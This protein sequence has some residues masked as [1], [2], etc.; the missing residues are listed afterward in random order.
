[1]KILRG[2]IFGIIFTLIASTAVGQGTRKGESKIFPSDKEIQGVCTVESIQFNLSTPC[3]ASEPAEGQVCWSDDDKTLAVG[4]PGGEVVG[5]MFQEMYIPGRVKNETGG[6][7]LNGTVVF[8]NGTSGGKFTV[9]KADAS[10]EELSETTIGVVTED[11]AHN[12]LGHVT[13]FGLVRGSVAQPIDT[14]GMTPGDDLYLSE[15]AGEWTDSKPASPAHATKVGTVG[16]ISATVGT[17]LVHVI[18][19]AEMY[20]MHDVADGLSTPTDKLLIAW[21]NPNSLWEQT[22]QL[23]YNFANDRL[24]INTNIPE[25]ALDVNGILTVAPYERHLQIPIASAVLGPTAPSLIVYNSVVAC[26]EFDAD[27]EV[28]YAT[29]EIGS[30]WV[31]GE[32]II[33]EVDW[34]PNNAAMSN[35]ETVKWDLRLRTIAEGEDADG[36]L[37]SATATHTDVSGATLQGLISHTAITLDFDDA[38]NPLVIDDHVYIEITRDMGGDS[39]ASDACITAFE[40]IY[41]SDGLP[42]TN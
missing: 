9:T 19:G 20:E 12:G 3:G 11:I 25:S 37:T 4:M 1:M 24:G 10:T 32:D 33:I 42:I 7:L 23:H 27:N 34:L 14:S 16:T 30:D 29:W 41:N 5:Q 28:M 18:N 36:T 8:I 38:N 40:V 26:R 6:T 17:I 15:T 39:F 21:N 22:P 35:G 31:G 2:I 13:T